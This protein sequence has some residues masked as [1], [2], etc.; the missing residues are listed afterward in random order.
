MNSGELVLLVLAGVLVGVLLSGLNMV[1]AAIGVGLVRHSVA[2]WVWLY[3]LLADGPKKRARREKIR[4]HV[5]EQLADADR[6]ASVDAL[7][8]QRELAVRVLLDAAWG[9]P[10]D[11]AWAIAA[12]AGRIRGLRRVGAGF[13]PLSLG[14]PILPTVLVRRPRL[15]DTIKDLMLDMR[16]DPG[17]SPV[18]LVGFG[19]SGKTVLASLIGHDPAV[20]RKYRDG[21]FWIHSCQGPS[22][23][24]YQI[25]LAHLHQKKRG[26]IGI[27]TDTHD[28]VA[29]LELLLAERS[30]LLIIDDVCDDE[31]WYVV[32][33]LS[34]VS[35]VLFTTSNA[36][37][38]EACLPGARSVNVSSLEPEEARSLLGRSAGAAPHQ[39]EGSAAADQLC[40]YVDYSAYGVVVCAQAIQEDGGGETAWADV[41]DLCSHGIDAVALRNWP[42]PSLAQLGLEIYRGARQQRAMNDSDGSQGSRDPRPSPGG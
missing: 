4:S 6:P 20:A 13:I 9:A 10:S 3:T 36:R 21:L 16:S 35:A 24:G 39:L 11:L 28:L 23:L 32:S 33:R 29:R 41:L 8:L 1:S 26:G 40:R 12:A 27:V 31:E 15:E 34:R 14:V 42:E 18:G 7:A 22:L 25:L 5:Y 38:A 17:R 2:G 19:G 30:C 37:R